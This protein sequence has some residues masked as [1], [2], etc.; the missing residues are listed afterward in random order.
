MRECSHLDGGIWVSGMREGERM[1][2]ARED[3]SVPLAVQRSDF[4]NRVS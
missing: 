4:F 3:G 1:S 2:E